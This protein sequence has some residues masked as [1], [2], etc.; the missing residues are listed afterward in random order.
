[1]K[2][3]SPTSEI[4]AYIYGGF[5]NGKTHLLIGVARKLK[6]TNV[7]VSYVNGTN[8]TLYE[9][10]GKT[11]SE[12]DLNN[13]LSKSEFLII[14]DLELRKEF[15][16]H[17]RLLYQLILNRYEKGKPILI[18]SNHSPEALIDKMVIGGEGKIIHGI[19]D[20]IIPG[21]DSDNEM[22]NRTLDRLREMCLFINFSEI[23]NKRHQIQVDFQKKFL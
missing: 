13:P 8:Q 18:S 14:D 5:G 9:I 6:E 20:K 11:V 22:K 15:I 10:I 23:S 17:S 21:Y 4:G 12:F 19:N 7:N 3:L 2:D 1:M 16:V